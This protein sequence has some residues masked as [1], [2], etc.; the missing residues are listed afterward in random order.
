[1]RTKPRFTH[2]SA[3]LLALLFCGRSALRAE[4]EPPAPTTQKPCISH[5]DQ[6]FNLTRHQEN[7]DLETDEYLLPGE[8][9]ADWS[10]LITVQRLRR[11]V[12]LEAAAK[13]IQTSFEKEFSATVS[14]LGQSNHHRLLQA[15]IP[16]QT[17]TQQ[18]RVLCLLSDGLQENASLV[19]IQFALRPSTGSPAA[20]DALFISWR[21]RLTELARQERTTV[22]RKTAR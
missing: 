18:H 14:S 15:N 13:F 21:D 6:V 10:Q 1:M 4:G 22:E 5:R 17:T 7:G 12:A 20:Q 11:P 8:S 2:L 9:L 16:E 19:V 3:C